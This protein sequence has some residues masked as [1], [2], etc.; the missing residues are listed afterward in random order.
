MVTW[1]I[2]KGSESQQARAEARK[3]IPALRTGASRKDWKP[4]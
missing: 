3:R 2:Q 1:V 4:F